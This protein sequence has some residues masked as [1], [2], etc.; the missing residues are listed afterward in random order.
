V[1]D[2]ARLLRGAG[3]ALGDEV[4]EASDVLE[5]DGGRVPWPRTPTP[6]RAIPTTWVVARALGSIDW[7][8]T[9]S[10]TT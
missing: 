9:S 10:S 1:E 7:Y 3:G 4:E 6:C 2:V 5:A 8:Q